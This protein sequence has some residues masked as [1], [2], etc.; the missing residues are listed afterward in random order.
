MTKREYFA[1]DLCTRRSKGLIKSGWIV[2]GVC[3]GISFVINLISFITAALLFNS[4]DFSRGLD[5]VME[6]LGEHGNFDYDVLVKELEGLE[7]TLG[8]SVNEFLE[9][10]LYI[11]LAVIIVLFVAAIVLAFFTAYRRNL[12]VSIISLI[13]SLMTGDFFLIGSAITLLV[14]VCILNREYKRYRKGD[15]PQ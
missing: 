6:K 2:F 7:D 11:S 5:Y 9:L 3:T 12:A 10:V 13:V 14:F 4:I 8:V 15:A 1:S